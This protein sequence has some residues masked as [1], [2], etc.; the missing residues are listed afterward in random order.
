M[1]R[2]RIGKRIEITSRDIEIFRALGYDPLMSC[3]NR[4]CDMHG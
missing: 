2:T 1:Q 4:D 3:V